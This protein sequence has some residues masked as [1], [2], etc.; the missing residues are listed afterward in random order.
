MYLSH[1]ISCRLLYHTFLMTFMILFT[2][3]IIWKHPIICNNIIPIDNVIEKY[4]NIRDSNTQCNIIGTKKIKG[5]LSNNIKIP[6]NFNLRHSQLWYIEYDDKVYNDL[7]KKNVK[8]LPK[9][10]EKTILNNNISNLHIDD[11]KKNEITQQVQNWF[12]NIKDKLIDTNII[13]INLDVISKKKYEKDTHY[14]C[15]VLTH[16]MNKNH[17]KVIEMIINYN[18]E[19]IKYAKV[20]GNMNEYEIY[21]L[22]LEKNDIISNLSYDINYD[23]S[24]LMSENIEDEKILKLDPLDDKDE[25][26]NF[27]CDHRKQFVMLNGYIEECKNQM[28]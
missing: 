10:I 5:T 20:I 28:I 16:R 25:I 23:I 12:K 3:T 19:E 17:G 13:V 15:V 27:I 4:K 26:D 11:N 24:T 1:F 6:A 2:I 9:N 14:K 22:N 7:M 18:K 8:Q 21:N